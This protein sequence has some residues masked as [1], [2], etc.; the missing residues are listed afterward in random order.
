[1]TG[2]KILEALGLVDEAYIEEAETGAVRTAFPLKKLLPLAACL[3]VVLLGAFVLKGIGP[4]ANEGGESLQEAPDNVVYYGEAENARENPDQNDEAVDFDVQFRGPDSSTMIV[5]IDA[6]T[7]DGFTATVEKNG[8]SDVPAAGTQI[9]V[10]FTY[11]ISVKT[12]TDTG[13]SVERTVPQEADFPVGTLVKVGYKDFDAD[14]VTLHVDSVML[15]EE[16]N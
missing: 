2:K 13:V 8:S 9:K 7:E 12:V 5:R 1:M 11:G 10:V 14:M 3:C 15:A 6:W 16:E 4:N